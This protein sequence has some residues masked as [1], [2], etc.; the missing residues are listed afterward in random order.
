MMKMTRRLDFTYKLANT[1]IQI[2]VNFFVRLKM[3]YVNTSR[4][5]NF[6]YMSSKQNTEENF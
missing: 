5:N 2:Y 4:T 1:K 3:N 6:I